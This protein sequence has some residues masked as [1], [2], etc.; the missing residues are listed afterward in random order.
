MLSTAAPPGRTGWFYTTMLCPQF[1]K[2]LS[3]DPNITQYR[4]LQCITP[5]WSPGIDTSPIN[6]CYRFKQIPPAAPVPNFFGSGG[7]L[8]S[9]WEAQ[10]WQQVLPSHQQVGTQSRYS[11]LAGWSGQPQEHLMPPVGSSYRPIS[12]PPAQP[13]LNYDYECRLRSRTAVRHY[14]H[15]ASNAP[16]NSA[17]IRLPIINQLSESSLK[18]ITLLNSDYKMFMKLLTVR[19]V[20]AKVAPSLIQKNQAGFV[21]GRNIYDQVDHKERL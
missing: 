14:S 21:P 19:I 2:M 1:W 11:S 3:H 5:Q 9:E 18:L 12:G 13:T 4:V 20:L 16:G 7:G 6:I 15:A 10:K 8:S 17:V